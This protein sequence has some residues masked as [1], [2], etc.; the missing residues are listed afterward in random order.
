MRLG[1]VGLGLGLGGLLGTD[2]VGGGAWRG[3][4]GGEGGEGGGGE[5]GG[6]LGRKG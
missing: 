6:S 4:E 2:R 1:E 5:H 3:G